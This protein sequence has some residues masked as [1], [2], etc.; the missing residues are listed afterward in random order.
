MSKLIR[1][2]DDVWE[3]LNS[4]ALEHN[5]SIGRMVESLVNGGAVC[6][7]NPEPTQPTEDLV[8]RLDSHPEDFIPEEDRAVLQNLG[9]GELP[10]CCQRIYENPE[11]VD[12]SLACKHWKKGYVNYYGRRIWHLQN[13]LTGGSYFDYFNK[14][15]G[16]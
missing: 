12:M 6:I 15:V 5:L 9:P 14:Y 8:D 13:S 10:E 16:A 7:S 11:E 4:K 3:K 1:V 2:N